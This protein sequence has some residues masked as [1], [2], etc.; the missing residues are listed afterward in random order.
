MGTPQGKRQATASNTSLHS[1]LERL[2]DMVMEKQP[3]SVEERKGLLD[4]LAEQLVHYQDPKLLE[5]KS[6]STLTKSE[7]DSVCEKIQLNY[8]GAIRFSKTKKLLD[9]IP[10]L[11]RSFLEQLETAKSVNVSDVCVSFFI[12]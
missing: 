6:F 12:C 3:R 11:P 5:P 1:M 8:K 10:E 9:G 2:I 7:W 4:T